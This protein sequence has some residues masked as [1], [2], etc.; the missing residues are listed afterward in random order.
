MMY[1]TS[2]YFPKNKLWK[3]I[4]N[5]LKSLDRRLIFE[6]DI[7]D[8]KRIII[9]K[10]NDLNKQFSRCKPVKASFWQGP[11]DKDF[12]LSLDGESIIGFT[13]LKGYTD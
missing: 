6:R 8:A 5:Y 7:S 10:I 9:K 3:E 12:I 4:Q 13:F 1:V 2:I 11:I